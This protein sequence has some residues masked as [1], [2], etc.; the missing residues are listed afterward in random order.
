[1]IEFPFGLRQALESGNCVLFLGAGMGHYMKDANGDSAPDGKSLAKELFDYF[2]IEVEATD[3]LA[4]VSQYIQIKKGSRIELET[5]IR[6]R[7]SNMNP[8]EHF[9]WLSTIKWKAIYTTNYDNCIQKA[10]DS[11]SKPP[12]EYH[13]IT[14]NS[15]ILNYDSRFQVPIYH[16]H[17]SLFTG[18]KQNII[19]TEKDYTK[20]KEKRRMMFDQLKLHIA[21]SNILYIGYSNNDSNWKQLLSEIAEEFSPNPLPYSYRIDP[22]TSDMD[23]EILKNDNIETIKCSLHEFTL[24]ASTILKDIKIDE[25]KMKTIQKNIPNDLIQTF[26]ASPTSVMRLLSSWEFVNNAQFN[27]KPNTHLFLKGEKP[28]WSLIGQGCYFSRDIE[29]EA[30][31]SIL[32]YVTG[33]STKP[34]ISLIHGAAGYGIT[35]LLMTLATKVVKDRAANVFFFKDGGEFKEGDIEF[36]SSISSDLKTIFFIDNAADNIEKISTIYKKFNDINKSCMFILGERT[37]EWNQTNSKIRTDA[38]PIKSLSDGE[39]DRLIKFLKD[40]GELNKLEHLPEDVQVFSIKKN[41]NRQLL[42]AIREATEGKS[43]DAILEDEFRGISSDFAKKAYLAVCCFYQHG[44]YIRENLLAEILDVNITDLYDRIRNNTDGIIIYD[45]IDESKGLYVARARHRLISEIVWQRCGEISLKQ[46]IAQDSLYSLNLMNKPDKDAFD[47]FIKHDGFVDILNTLEDKIK[48]FDRACNK[49][50]DNPYV[51][52]HYARMLLRSGN[53]ILA[54][55]QIEEAI[56]IAP[57]ARILYHT[58]GM[59]LSEMVKESNTDIARKRLSQSE[60][61]FKKGLNLYEK[62]EYC[63]QGLA[64]LYLTWAKLSKDENEQIEYITKAE[65][66]INIGLKKVKQKEGLLILSSKIEDFLGDQPSR[67][68][69]LEKA[70]YENKSSVIV[71]YLLARAYTHNSRFQDTLDIL[72][73]VVFDNAPEFRLFI[74]YALALLKLGHTYDEAIAILKQSTLYGLSDP[75]F[76]AILGG[77]LFMNKKFSEAEQ[78]F[79]ETINRNI[80]TMELYTVYFKPFNLNNFE[81]IRMYGVVKKVKPGCAIIDVEEY[82][83]FMCPGSK[84]NG[85]VMEEGMKVSFTPAFTPKGRIA[86]EIMLANQEEKSSS[87]VTKVIN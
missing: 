49:D 76:I 24:T 57:D 66:I 71:R 18:S 51:K 60:D 15:D 4:K 40:N 79:A 73:P 11:N 50:P 26:E 56:S 52:Q 69:H 82:P 87:E 29:E 84:Y 30:Y 36:A 45:C 75:R 37:N 86:Q 59:I 42:V 5:Y 6:Q 16:L 1:M 85:I 72:K 68:E 23:V 3:D 62:D 21:S 38:Y 44:A 13:T 34:K 25:L 77:M 61:C 14:Y 67:I 53:F 39:I 81:E 43:F 35:T 64:E 19:I 32:D 70:L 17:G 10:Y 12:Q 33:F 80:S 20:Y 78:V 28:D 65:D 41:Y 63:H 2:K 9:K 8:D 48:F 46:Q 47:R 83:E 31:D 55:N 22:H 74:E 7:F 27:S 54:L 58:K